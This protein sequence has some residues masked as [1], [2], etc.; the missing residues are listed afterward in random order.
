MLKYMIQHL[1]GMKT[2]HL[3]LLPMILSLMPI[4][5]LVWLG[6]AGS[7]HTPLQN[8]LSCITFFLWGC[9]GLPMIIRKEM[10]WFV[11]MRGWAAVVQGIIL[12]SIGWGTAMGFVILLFEPL[13]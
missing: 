6:S 4:L 8:T 3:V 1:Y 11:T 2:S 13:P 12:V 5:I 9:V 7:R 10:P